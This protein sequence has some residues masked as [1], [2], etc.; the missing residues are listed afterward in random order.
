MVVIFI[1]LQLYFFIRK[2]LITKEIGSDNKF[3]LCIK[4]MNRIARF[5]EN[6]VFRNEDDEE[7]GWVDYLSKQASSYL[8]TQMNDLWMRGKSFATARLPSIGKRNTVAL[9][10]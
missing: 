1:S 8:P 6:S 9:P 10:L 5:T 7:Q 3:L 2:I 4:S